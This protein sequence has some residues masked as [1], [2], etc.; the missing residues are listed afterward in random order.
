MMKYK[1]KMHGKYFVLNLS[2]EL[3]DKALKVINERGDGKDDV[4]YKIYTGELN[5]NGELVDVLGVEILTIGLNKA[6]A[7]SKLQEEKVY[8]KNNVGELKLLQEAEYNL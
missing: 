4:G 1:K 7:K 2:Q 8:F 3:Y 5:H 6:A